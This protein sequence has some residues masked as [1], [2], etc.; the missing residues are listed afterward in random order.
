[1]NFSKFLCKDPLDYLCDI[2]APFA[3]LEKPPE[4]SGFPVYHG[5]MEWSVEKKEK[6][7]M[8]MDHGLNEQLTD[9]RKQITL[10][11]DDEREAALDILNYY[12]KI[13]FKSISNP[14]SK[15][16]LCLRC[17]NYVYSIISD[18]ET[19]LSLGDAPGEW[20]PYV[21]EKYPLSKCFAMSSKDVDWDFD[22]INLRTCNFLYGESKTGNINDEYKWL[23]QFL[24]ERSGPMDLVLCNYTGNEKT[25]LAEIYVALNTL[26]K[27][28]KIEYKDPHPQPLSFEEIS[29]GISESND[30]VTERLGGN[31]V[32]R[33]Q[34]TWSVKMGQII[35]LVANSFEETVLY[36]PVTAEPENYVRYLV[37]KNY[38]GCDPEMIKN[39]YKLNIPGEFREWLT[40]VNNMLGMYQSKIC[41][42]IIKYPDISYPKPKDLSRLMLALELKGSTA[43]EV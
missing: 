8:F 39:V 3:R 11:R 1:M 6:D 5:R 23:T 18:V 40:Q 41:A 38:L 26:K 17:I 43:V 16:E 27:Y 13:G 34:D 2:P 7:T 33:L 20:I 9:N 32:I 30:R 42:E 14:V 28:E 37:C 22:R 4:F 10:I 35:Y 19:F 12:S 15:D 36:K 24:H 25:I 31:L 29:I 21:Q